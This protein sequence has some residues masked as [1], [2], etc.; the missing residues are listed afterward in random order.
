MI[1]ERHDSSVSLSQAH[2]HGLACCPS[3]L[4]SS[5]FYESFSD[6]ILTA[7]APFPTK[8]RFKLHG[9]NEKGSIND[10]TI[11]LSIP[12]L[13]GI[14]RSYF[15]YLLSNYFRKPMLGHFYMHHGIVI[16]K[17]SWFSATHVLYQDLVLSPK[18]SAHHQ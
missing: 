3:N 8:L 6:G 1:N 2:Q 14:L 9:L 10:R 18:M 5:L 11:G 13:Y 15:V 7:S 12:N 16:L 17:H 4:F